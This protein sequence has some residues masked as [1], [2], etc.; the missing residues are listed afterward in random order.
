MIITSKLSNEAL[1][2]AIYKAAAEYSKLIDNS[3]LIIGKNKNTDYY[4][5]QCYFEKKHFMHLLGI[6]SE[7]LTA[8]EFYDKCDLYN[9]G[10]GEGIS[11]TDCSPSRN[12]NRTTINEKCSCCADMLRIQD[13]KYMKVGLKDKISQYV[14]FTYGYG[15][16]ATL[17]FKKQHDTSFPLT[18]IPR[19]IDEFVTQKHKIVF[20]LQ[21]SSKEE[22]Y[23]HLLVEIKKGLF[24]EVYNELPNEIK[25]L[26]KGE[27][28]RQ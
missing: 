21:K 18:L 1:L 5:F 13:A 16:E 12:H 6:D 8:T 11:L 17:G 14:D 27:H 24:A 2:K 4:G 3:Y 20:V 10:E 25:R 15:S 19:G 9:K 26:I 23:Q 22:K 7:T 28:I